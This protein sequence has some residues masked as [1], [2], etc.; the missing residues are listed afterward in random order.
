M[1]RPSNFFEMSHKVSPGCTVYV[2]ESGMATAVSG[3]LGFEDANTVLRIRACS[4]PD[5]QAL[6]DMY[7]ITSEIIP[8][9]KVI[10]PN[11]VTDSNR[12]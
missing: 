1:V 7:C 11:A 2:F 8:F 12:S 3:V 4:R 9:F 5:V 6:T 10:D